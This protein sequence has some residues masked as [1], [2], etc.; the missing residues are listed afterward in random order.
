VLPS[1][2]FVRMY[3]ELFKML[4]ER[5]PEHLRR[6]WLEI[7]GLQRSLLGPYVARAGFRGMYEYWDHIRIEENCEMDLEYG[8]DYFHL[9]MVK[10]PSLSKNLD[11]DAGLCAVYC[12]HCAGWIVP[13]FES[14]GYH[15]VYDMISRSEPRCEMWVFADPEPAREKAKAAKL[16]AEP[17]PKGY[18]GLQD[19]HEEHSRE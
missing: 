16:L 19:L 1:D 18:A 2:H 7:A 10:C 12:D 11:N 14:Y 9:R 8:E 15:V 5:G 3:N 17:Y 13:V 4:E 6:Y